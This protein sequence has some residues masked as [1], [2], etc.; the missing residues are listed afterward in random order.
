[1]TATDFVPLTYIPIF[2]G[3]QTGVSRKHNSACVKGK[4]H[5]ALKK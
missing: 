2:M 3:D 4:V 1:M 5:A